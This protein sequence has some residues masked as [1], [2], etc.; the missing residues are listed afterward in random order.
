MNKK[1]DINNETEE[2][3]EMI[4]DIKNRESALKKIQESI[5]K[6]I[7]KKRVNNQFNINNQI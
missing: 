4:E 3:N 6:Q 7:L 1:Q 5:M 2:L